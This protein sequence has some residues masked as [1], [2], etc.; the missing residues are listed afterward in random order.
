ME[1]S[2][3]SLRQV[4]KQFHVSEKSVLQARDLLAEAPDLAAQV[5]GCALSLAAAYQLAQERKR[6]TEQK[7]KNAEK[8]AEFSDAISNGEIT[9]EEALQ[10][11]LEAK[12][13]E[14]ERAR[15]DAEA[16]HIWFARLVELMRWVA[17]NVASRTDE[18]LAW[19]SEPGA[20]GSEAAPPPDELAAAVKQLQRVLSLTIKRKG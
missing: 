14:D 6:Q 20:P 8:V 9:V 4:A 5:E 3:V 19:Y 12:Q 7:A 18:D 2:A 16:R 1:T 10:K 15:H 11:A 13:A 17:D